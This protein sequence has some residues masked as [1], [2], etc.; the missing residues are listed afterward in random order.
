[1]K[2]TYDIIIGII[3]SII[4]LGILHLINR[5][6]IKMIYKKIIGYY[7]EVDNNLNPNYPGESYE[8]SFSMNY[9]R[10]APELTIR[11]IPGKPGKA[12]WLSIFPVNSPNFYHLIGSF[13]Y[14]KNKYIEDKDFDFNDVG[15]HNIYIVPQDEFIQVEITGI[16]HNYERRSYTIKKV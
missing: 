16:K 14:I 11:F 6:R 4:T 5:Y 15:I 10:D 3:S 1:M 13:K 12:D 2:I 7:E 8:V 9:F